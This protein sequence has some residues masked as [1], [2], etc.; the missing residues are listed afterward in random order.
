[1]LDCE[2]YGEV[3]KRMYEEIFRATGHELDV[4]LMTDNRT[5]MMD[6]LIG[7]GLP[8]HRS[9]VLKAV[10]KFIAKASRIR[11]EYSGDKEAV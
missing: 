1:M 11:S 10:M 2:V 8:K 7:H 9:E 3:R 5:W 4:R 6:V